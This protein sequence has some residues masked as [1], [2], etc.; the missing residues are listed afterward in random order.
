MKT[1]LLPTD[2]SNN[3]LLACDFAVSKLGEKDTNYV[4]NY[5]YN[6]PMGGTSGLFYLMEELQKQG[7]ADLKEF[8]HKIETDFQLNESQVESHLIQGN[9][10]DE[11]TNLAEQVNASC[12]VVGTKGSSG[13]KEVL[14][15]SN[16]L[17]LIKSTKHTLYIVPEN[18]KELMLN[19]IIIAYD[20]K[21]MDPKTAKEAIYFAKKH[22]LPIE[23]LHIRLK[24]ESPIQD[25]S[26][27]KSFFT[28]IEVDVHEVWGESIE[29]GLKKGTEKA[30][31][32]LVM[33]YRKKSF[34]ER[35][36]NISDTRDAVMQAKLPML[37]V[38]E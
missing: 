36:F 7:K 28:G 5:V 9:F 27:I 16:T 32:I 2:F 17:Q 38:P 29:D 25:W 6:I 34:W 14:V 24:D 3:S 26:K 33:T 23:L 18:Y 37:I 4:L 11:T 21:E 20:G 12:I 1:I 8:K 19:K 22:Q 10:V 30:E 35:F 15:G 13:L 31:G